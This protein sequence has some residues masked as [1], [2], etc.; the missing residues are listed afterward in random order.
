MLLD[1]FRIPAPER[2][3]EVHWEWAHSNAWLEWYGL[4]SRGA[5]R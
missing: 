3:S 2:E 5:D 1:A 4:H